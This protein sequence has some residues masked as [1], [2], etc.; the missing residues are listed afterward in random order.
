VKH[1]VRHL[2]RFPSGTTYLPTEEVVQRLRGQ[3]AFFV[4]HPHQRPDEL[5]ALLAKLIAESAPPAAIDAAVAGRKCTFSVVL[6]DDL[7]PDSMDYLSFDVR[8]DESILFGYRD[9]QH[10]ADVSALLE[11]CTRLLDYD[12]VLL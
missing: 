9:E 10:L 7:A 1:A 8:P 2:E 4:A 11:R 6:A 3:F 5:G 12:A